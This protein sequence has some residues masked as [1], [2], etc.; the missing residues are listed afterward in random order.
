[1]GKRASKD[2]HKRRLNVVE[3]T[4]ADVGWSGRIVRTLADQ[5]GVTR[6]TVYEYRREVM[7]EIAE[8]YRGPDIEQTR[9]EFGL[10]PT[11]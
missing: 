4:M 5:F 2:E 1:M 3:K 8:A 7:A 11:P 10:P 9:A 6:Q